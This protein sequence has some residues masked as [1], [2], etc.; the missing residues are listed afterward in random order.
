MTDDLRPAASLPAA[1]AMRIAGWLVIGA[2]LVT[3]SLTA[4]SAF[5]GEEVHWWSWVTPFVLILIVSDLTFQFLHNRKRLRRALIAAI[6][7]LTSVILVEQFRQMSNL[8]SQTNSS[9]EA[10]SRPNL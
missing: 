10:I 6:L 3:L 4:V 1:R 9:S 2:S 7:I 5:A 8:R